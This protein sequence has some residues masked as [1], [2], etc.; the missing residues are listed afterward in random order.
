MSKE[1]ARKCVRGVGGVVVDMVGGCWVEE[2]FREG[3]RG[4]GSG[5]S[6]TISMYTYMT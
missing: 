6:A 4:R 1:R 2:G 3:R 5:G